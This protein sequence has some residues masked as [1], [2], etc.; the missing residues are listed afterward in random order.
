[1]TPPEPAGALRDISD[2]ALWVAVYRAMESEKPQPLFRDPHARRLAGARGEQVL[3]TMKQAK[4]YAWAMIIRTH[5]FDQFV[6]DRVAQG[7]D[8]VVNLAAGLDTRPYRMALPPD[9]DWVEVDLPRM[10]EYKSDILRDETPVC[11]LERVALDLADVDARRA[12]LRRLGERGRRAVVLTEGLLIYL[13]SGQVATLATDLGGLPAFR[14]WVTDLASPGLLKRMEKTWG[15]EVARAGAPFR[16]APVE[17]PA[18]FERFGWHP[19]EVRSS[20]HAAGRAGILPW[21]FRPFMIFPE[22]KRWDPKQVWS[23]Q[24]L[25][26]RA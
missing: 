2:T 15:A 12:L 6:L 19:L 13:E 21:F 23:G 3:R 1:M 16:F 7:A 9:L 14:W 20:F 10:I 4:T 18:F 26:E 24:C 25:L 17:G 8:L 22:R 5:A 11:R